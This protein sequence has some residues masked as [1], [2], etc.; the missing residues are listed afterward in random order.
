MFWAR[1]STCR[2]ISYISRTDSWMQPLTLFLLLASSTDSHRM[3][4][5]FTQWRPEASTNKS[6][7]S[8][9][10][11]Y[12]SQLVL[13]P[14]D[15]TP[16]SRP[17]YLIAPLGP[18]MKNHKWDQRS[19]HR[20]LWDVTG[21]RVTLPT[22]WSQTPLLILLPR[23]DCPVFLNFVQQP[24]LHSNITFLERAFSQKCLPSLY[25]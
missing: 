5:V 3:G 24:A 14:W 7:L 19:Y 1:N 2:N 25:Y 17:S 11:E 10:P 20:L 22:F 8:A 4:T 23:D 12:F 15:L 6:T 21:T 18:N 13:F 9:W 16:L